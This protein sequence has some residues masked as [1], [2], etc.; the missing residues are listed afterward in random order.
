VS[1]LKIQPATQVT[2]AWQSV[3][4]PWW[5]RPPTPLAAD[6]DYQVTIPKAAIQN[7]GG[8][9][10]SSNVT[11][12]FGTQAVATP[13]PTASPVPALEPAAVGPP[14]ATGWPSGALMTLPG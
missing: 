13:G 4:R 5:S 7:T 12:E 3:P 10:L 6:T 8:Q 9:T 1:A 2:V 14:P 11:I